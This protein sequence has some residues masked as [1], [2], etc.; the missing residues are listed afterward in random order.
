MVTQ[1]KKISPGAL[2]WH[3]VERHFLQRNSRLKHEG[4]LPVTE[5]APVTSFSA[6][7]E[8]QSEDSLRAKGGAYAAF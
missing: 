6:E 5:T 1:S 3:L 7:S 8:T 4:I 2:S